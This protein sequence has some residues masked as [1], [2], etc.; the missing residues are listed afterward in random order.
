M[1]IEVECEGTCP[2]EAKED[3]DIIADSLAANISSMSG[4]VDTDVDSIK[5]EED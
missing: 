5:I 3:A 1:V 4:I 2:D